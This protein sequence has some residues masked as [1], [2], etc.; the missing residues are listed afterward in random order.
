MAN[1]K[2]PRVPR[3]CEQCN[4]YFEAHAS[5]VRRGG[6]RFCSP[7]CWYDWN[8][9]PLGE[10]FK[11]YLSPPNENGCIEWTGGR[12]GAGYGR[13]REG[14]M[15]PQLQAHRVAFELAGGVIPDGHEV[16]HHCDNPP[17]VNVAH[18]FAGTQ[19]DNM[20]D[21]A[22][23]GRQWKMARRLT[24]EAAKRQEA[25]GLAEELLDGD[26]DG[27]LLDVVDGL[28]DRL[29]LGEALGD[30]EGECDGLGELLRLALGLALGDAEGEA[31]SVVEGEAD[32]DALGLGDAEGEAKAPIRNSK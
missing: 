25:D 1:H 18:L 28:A 2:V 23:K 5:E 7:Q 27:L 3:Y 26:A 29:R 31:L 15:K 6:G 8:T 16:L 14:R 13:I 10:R 30:A 11:R 9:A 12:S 22:S 21:M 20:R 4:K 32:G 24:R 17:C 19:S